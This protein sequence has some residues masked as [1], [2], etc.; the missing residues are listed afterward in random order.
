MEVFFSYQIPKT[1]DETISFVSFFPFL[2]TCS[3]VCVEDQFAGYCEAYL[4]TSGLCETGTKCCIS[5]DNYSGKLTDLRTPILQINETIPLITAE[6]IALI[7]KPNATT[8][9]S[10]PV[11][12]LTENMA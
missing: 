11:S 2:E 3:G 10:K 9:M 12:Q 5:K 4:I 7:K 8:K 1:K 6:L